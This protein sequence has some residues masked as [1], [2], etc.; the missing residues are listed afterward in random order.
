MAALLALCEPSR[1]G[2]SMLGRLIGAVFSGRGRVVAAGAAA[3]AGLA[4]FAVS[5]AATNT[6]QV[7]KVRLGGDSAET[8]IVIDLNGAASAK[9]LSDG[10]ADR[11]VVIQL[12]N[13]SAAATQQGAAYGL[14]KDWIVDD[15]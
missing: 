4:A 3:L 11:R 1:R 14:V 8:R 13:A 2:G 6:A 15:A 9:V 10:A 7:L 5:H 12:G